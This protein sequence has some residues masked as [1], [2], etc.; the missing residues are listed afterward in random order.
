VTGLLKNYM[1]QTHN[2][3]VPIEHH[4]VPKKRILR[5]PVKEKNPA[6]TCSGRV[7]L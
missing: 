7:G 1:R 2:A 5:S 6:L 4:Q 3:V